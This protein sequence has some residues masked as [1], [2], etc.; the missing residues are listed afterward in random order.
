MISRWK[1][2]FYDLRNTRDG[3][4]F[5]VC[6]ISLFLEVGGFITAGILSIIFFGGF[7]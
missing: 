6:L 4:I 1:E 3:V 5:T 7:Y 2:L